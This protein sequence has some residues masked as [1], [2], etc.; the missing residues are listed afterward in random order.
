MFIRLR[1]F[2]LMDAHLVG[3]WL[4]AVQWFTIGWL[5][6]IKPHTNLSKLPCTSCSCRKALHNSRHNNSNGH[7]LQPW[8]DWPDKQVMRCFAMNHCTISTPVTLSD[9]FLHL[10]LSHSTACC[11]QGWELGLNLQGDPLCKHA[12]GCWG[13]NK[14]QKRCGA[15][16][17]PCCRAC[18]TLKNTSVAACSATHWVASRTL[19]PQHTPSWHSLTWRSAQHPAACPCAA[20]PLTPGTSAAQ[21]LHR[22]MQ[23]LCWG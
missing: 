18:L 7:K 17:R 5:W 4:R 11:E 14:A 13:A 20:P 9:C 23:Q 2:N 8:R 6:G 12:C 19:K 21:P 15:T 22:R 16:D 3:T 1:N 10:S